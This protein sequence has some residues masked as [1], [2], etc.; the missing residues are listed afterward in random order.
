MRVYHFI[1]RKFGLQA[2]RRKRLK[3]ALIDQ[4]NDPF[5]LL[6]FA[7]RDPEERKAFGQVKNGLAAYSG[8]L[9]FSANWSNPVQWSHYAEQQK[10]LCLGFDVPDS[11]V[12]PVKYRSRRLKPDPQAIREMISEGPAAHAMMLDLV[13]TKFSHWRY[14]NEHRMFVQLEEKDA[15]GLY[16]FD[17]SDKLVLREV[18]V[19]QSANIS[20]AE[21]RRALGRNVHAVAVFKARLAFQLFRVVR[22]KRDALWM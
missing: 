20:R 18:I 17:F 8:L 5:E 13:T 14:E 2:L 10:G 11:E 16:F 15:R 7:T 6:G 3:V 4:L 9:C 1:N 22:Q 21:L 19:G 12:V